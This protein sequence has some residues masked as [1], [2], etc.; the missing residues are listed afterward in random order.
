MNLSNRRRFIRRL[1]PTHKTNWQFCSLVRS[2]SLLIPIPEYAA[3]SSKV[4]L[5]FSQIGTSFI[6]KLDMPPR[7]AARPADMCAD[8]SLRLAQEVVAQN[9]F[10]CLL[11]L[12][13][14]R[15]GKSGVT[16]QDGLAADGKGVFLVR[17]RPGYSS[18]GSGPA[19]WTNFSSIR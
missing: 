9:H 2:R 18:S 16:E 6:G 4:K 19:N 7:C 10:L 1:L 14:E 11:W 5:L 8:H 13:G 3:A 17:L 12:G 15:G